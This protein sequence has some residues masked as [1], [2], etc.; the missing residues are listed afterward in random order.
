MANLTIPAMGNFYD[1]PT[2]EFVSL[3]D[4]IEHLCIR[5]IN[6]SGNSYS[7]ECCIWLSRNLLKKCVNVQIIDFSDMFE[8]RPTDEINKC[9]YV[10][11]NAV[12]EYKILDFNIS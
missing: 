4:N 9:V 11:L 6:L 7:L 2:K 10:L 5:S 8:N 1:Q 3:F 12:K